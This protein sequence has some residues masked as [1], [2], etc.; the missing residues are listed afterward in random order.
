MRNGWFIFIAFIALLM[1]SC[2]NQPN[3]KGEFIIKNPNNDKEIRI[4]YFNDGNIEYIQEVKNDTPEGFFI[5][6]YQSGLTKNTGRIVNGKKEGTGVVFYPDGTTNS[7][8]IYKNDQQ[9]GFFWLF[10]KEKNLVEKRE[11]LTIK[12]KNSMNQWIKF[13]QMMQPVF[14]ESNFISLSAAKD[15]IKT[16]EPYILTVSLE[17]SFNKEYMAV[18]IGPFDEQFNLPANSKCDTLIAKNF[19]SIY[20]TTNYKNGTNTIRGLVKDMSYSGDKSETRIRN[21]YFSKD[22]LV[23]K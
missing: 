1:V 15:T 21:I 13:D 3:D 11:Y 10:D 14:S 7:V 5:N 6:F 12:G 18:V 2:G 22:F 8:G 9:Y 20:Q 23:K 16:G 17:A 4:K 19:I